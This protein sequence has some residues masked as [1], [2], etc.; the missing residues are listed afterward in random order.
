MCVDEN[1]GF[2]QTVCTSLC[3]IT[4]CEL[5]LTTKKDWQIALKSSP[6]SSQGWVTMIC[7][8]AHAQTE[9][10]GSHWKKF[11][12]RLEQQGGARCV[13]PL[14]SGGTQ[15]WKHPLQQPRTIVINNNHMQR[16]YETILKPG[17]Q[18]TRACLQ[19]TR[20]TTSHHAAPWRAVLRSTVRINSHQFAPIEPCSIFCARPRDF[21]AAR[22]RL[23]AKLGLFN[24]LGQKGLSKTLVQTNGFCYPSSSSFFCT[25]FVVFLVKT[26]LLFFK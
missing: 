13:P 15:P 18:Y 16:Q 3:V 4:E 10:W 21:A 7:W 20:R 2:F 23:Q 22:L 1:I 25:S 9:I 6:P 17:L 11:P 14:F 8:S 19:Y 26:A 24:V 5:H 12:F